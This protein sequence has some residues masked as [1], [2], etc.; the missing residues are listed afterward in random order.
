MNAIILLGPAGL[1]SCMPASYGTIFFRYFWL[2]LF[3]Y[4]RKLVGNILQVNLASL[5]IKPV[6]I[7]VVDPIAL[8]A[9]KK[10]FQRQLKD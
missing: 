10:S 8:D 9:S 1:I 5:P 2:I 4:L 6:G 3:T 7:D